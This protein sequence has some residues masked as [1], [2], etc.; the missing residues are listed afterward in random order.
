MQSCFNR[1]HAGAGGFGH[2]QLAAPFLRQRKQC[3]IFWRQLLQRVLQ[4]IEF[5]GTHRT[6]RLRDIFVLLAKRRENPAQ[7]LPPQVIDA[8]VA[9]Q[10]KQPG[11][12]LRRLVQTPQRPN[13]FDEN[14][15]GKILDRIAPPGNRINKP[16][17]ASLVT[18]NERPLGGFFAL[19]GP[20][21]KFAECDRCR[22][23]LRGASVCFA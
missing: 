5:L 19:L 21:N 17:D 6:R 11:L 20:P 10:P 3:A 18:D 4:C 8:G 23:F 14:Q 7:L 12:E 2:L 16:R 15:L 1:H 13:H 22:L 9:R